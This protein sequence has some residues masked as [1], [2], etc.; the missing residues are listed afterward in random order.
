KG[1]KATQAYSLWTCLNNRCCTLTDLQPWHRL[2]GFLGPQ[3]FVRVA[4]VAASIRFANV[5]DERLGVLELD[6]QRPDQCG[7]GLDRER[8]G[9][10]PELQPDSIGCHSRLLSI[11]AAK[12]DEITTVL[13]GSVNPAP[14]N[15]RA[16]RPAGR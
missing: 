4:T 8:L 14:R 16:G 2:D 6:L 13:S 12:Q 11:D 10:H 9:A 7:L 5:G 3:R 15:E 1:L